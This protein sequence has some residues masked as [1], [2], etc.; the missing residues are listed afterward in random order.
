[1]YTEKTEGTTLR[2]VAVRR[3][4]QGSLM[5]RASGRRHWQER[6]VGLAPLQYGSSL[7]HQGQSCR[8]ELS[9]RKLRFP[10]LPKTHGRPSRC[11]PLGNGSFS[12]GSSLGIETASSYA[13]LA[14]SPFPTIALAHYT[15]STTKSHVSCASRSTDPGM[16]P[17]TFMGHPSFGR[18]LARHSSCELATAT[19]P[20]RTIASPC[21]PE[22]MPGDTRGP[23][24]VAL[25]IRRNRG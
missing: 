20:R 1:M 11:S 9:R 13:F 17:P 23:V 6:H 19:I 2:A 7:H 24:L 4:H 25:W 21:H 8:C 12:L 16:H 5:Q 10:S 18:S 14:F 22:D 3:S 15:R